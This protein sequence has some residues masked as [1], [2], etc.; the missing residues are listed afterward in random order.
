M[1]TIQNRVKGALQSLGPKGVGVVEWER[2]Q[3]QK[4]LY[5]AEIRRAVLSLHGEAQRQ[6]FASEDQDIQR[7]QAKRSL[8]QQ[9]QNIEAGRAKLD[10]FQQD[11]SA[12]Q[13]DKSAMAG[14]SS[15]FEAVLVDPNLPQQVRTQLTRDSAIYGKLS[16][17]EYRQQFAHDSLS[18]AREAVQQHHREEMKAGI[19]DRLAR[20]DYGEDEAVH[21]AATGLGELLDSGADPQQVAKQDLEMRMGVAKGTKEKMAKERLSTFIL[22][23]LAAL[24]PESPEA[25]Q[26][27]TVLAAY[28]AGGIPN[29]KVTEVVQ[30][31][32]TPPQQKGAS[33]IE[34]RKTAHAMAVEEAKA[35]K[36]D[37]PKALRAIYEGH[38]ADLMQEGRQGK[39]PDP[40]GQIPFEQAGT[41]PPGQPQQPSAPPSLPPDSPAA[42]ATPQKTAASVQQAQQLTAPTDPE[43]AKQAA[44]EALKAGDKARAI[45]ILKAAGLDPDAP[46]PAKPKGKR[47]EAEH[48]GPNT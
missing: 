44:I 25:D 34:L 40:S 4:E 21:K 24:P 5:D 39:Q 18:A 9:D 42:P 20:G 41:Q 16:T 14:G 1:P 27:E 2:G 37:D 30:K 26:L 31:A 36:I 3:K 43:G 32:M 46:A 29:D 48:V 17:P 47:R 33:P 7:A 6:S 28:Q 8:A 15:P 38:L 23:Q 19:Q 45:E 22:T 12:Q 35:L 13:A 10:A 11:R